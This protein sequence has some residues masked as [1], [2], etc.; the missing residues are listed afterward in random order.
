MSLNHW[1][2]AD[3]KAEREK[4]VSDTFEELEQLAGAGD[5]AAA[6][7]R[8]IALLRERKEYGQLFDAILLKKRSDLS[9]PLAQPT[10]LDVPEEHRQTMEDAYVAAAREVG[11]LFLADG[12]IGQA[13]PYF[14]TIGEPQPVRDA[15]D[16]LPVP[17]EVDDSTEELIEIALH[18]GAH[19]V[20]GLEI[21]LRTHGTCNTVTA[22]DGALQHNLL[23]GDDQKQAAAM[24]V[25][26]LY[27]DLCQTVR[28]EVEQRLAALPPTASLK[29]LIAGRDWLF[30]DDNYHIDVSHLNA[31]VRF[32]RAFDAKT[33]ELPQVTELAEY[34]SN[35][36]QQFQY[37]A[38]P[39]FDDFYVAHVHFFKA[40]SGDNVN[41]HLAY[42]QGKLDAEPDQEDKPYLAFPLLDLLLRVD[43]K[44]EAIAIA[45]QYLAGINDPNVFSF[46]Q[47]CWDTG[48]LEAYRR[49][50]KARGDLVGF[51]AALVDG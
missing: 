37:P 2:A 1:L 24:M 50:S 47:L 5:R 28:H 49:V 22:F 40:L 17:R 43:R 29:E 20:K 39:P 46:A 36:S 33:P 41:E 18:H 44:D 14:R 27:Q 23:N 34:G 38:D 25:R 45:E 19:P 4:T 35:L 7:D 32:A 3:S 10:S 15:L 12:K 11:E 8:L 31:V 42:F 26:E 51:T 6:V 13:W 30:A 9:L 21:M 16:Q 48:E